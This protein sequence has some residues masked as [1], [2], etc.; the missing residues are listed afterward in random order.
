MDCDH[1]AT[2]YAAMRADAQSAG[3]DQ[4]RQLID[5][6]RQQLG[7]DA[8]GLQVPLGMRADDSVFVLSAC[9][10]SQTCSLLGD[11]ATGRHLY[12]LLLPYQDR[13]IT[14]ASGGNERACAAA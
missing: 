6:C 11:I 13:I 4:L 9:R 3:S 12:H 5:L 1:K 10:L 2:E 14:L 7:H 8:P